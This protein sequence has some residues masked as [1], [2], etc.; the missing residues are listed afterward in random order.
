[1]PGG[2]WL[3]P[4]AALG[5]GVAWL[6]LGILVT[7][8][9]GQPFP[10]LIRFGA[11]WVA[12]PWLAA[13]FWAPSAPATAPRL[14][15]AAGLAILLA[16]ALAFVH[17]ARLG[18]P[19]SWFTDSPDHIGTVRRMLASGDAFPTDAFFRDAGPAGADPR[20]GLWHPAVALLCGLSHTDPVTG[21]RALSAVLAPLF[22]LNAASFAWWLGGGMAAAAGA[23]GL[24]LTYGGGL[25][26][27]YLREAVFATKLADQLALAAAAALLGDLAARTVRSRLA[28]AG[29]MAGTIAVHVFGAIQF[30]IAFGALALGTVIRD[31][32][33]SRDAGRVLLTASTGAA[34]VLPYLAWRAHGS[35]APNNIIHTEPQGLLELA[36]GLTIVS[37][38]AVWDWLGPTFVL[39]PLS[40]LAWWRARHTPAA[41]YL[42]TTT[43]AVAGLM[44]LPP[45]VTLLLPRLGYLLMRLPWL[46]PSSAA[47]AFLL[48][49]AHTAWRSGQRWP[50]LGAAVVLG[51]ALAGPSLD[52]A[53]VLV[54]PRPAQ[55]AEAGASVERWGDALAWMQDSLPA[56]SVVLSDPAT[57]YSIPMRT[58]HWV[59]ALVDQHS[60]PNDSLALARILDARDALDPYESWERTTSV[61]RRWGATAIAL[62]G[63][64]DSAPQLDYWAP[65]GPWYEAAR[66]RFDE[67]PAAFERVYDHDRFTVYV[68]RPAALDALPTGTRPRP[69][70]RPLE[71]TDV[72]RTLGPGLPG[73]VA[74]GCSP[75]ALAP[76]DT[77]S[78]Q[79]EWHTDRALPA[80]SYHVAVRFDRP[81]PAGTPAMPLA[82]SK[83]WRKLVE[84]VRRERYR[85]RA[86]HLPVDGAFGVDRWQPGE[87]V[88]DRFRVEVPLDVAAGDY[89]VKVVMTRSPHYPNLRV[90]DLTSDDDVLDGLAVGT[91]R[92]RPRGGR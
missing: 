1:G 46:L 23:W 45:V 32:A 59:T 49:L 26:T 75:A 48:V 22:V 2:A 64:W 43:T 9:L 4:G 27:Q 28:V 30:A 19:L 44:F 21:W 13:A 25:G 39:F 86:D 14:S 81:L 89:A 67:Q 55:V 34:I 88:L 36:P 20:K 62:N 53:R 72:S 3:A 38:G 15:R 84:R 77:L 57:S 83:V 71:P 79:I 52:G 16:A 85:F 33:W 58:R 12:L 61:L 78:G 90:W 35:Y 10:V 60:S 29:L 70:V 76:G 63:R 24:L 69:F 54:D 65:D 17:V 8:L 87:V 82:V 51:L 73:L 74:F 40:W 47:V 66:A 68:I 11:P 37:V 50:A 31:R 7:R 56:G 42:F 92:V 18:T 41:L 80:G 5:Y 91:V 6:G